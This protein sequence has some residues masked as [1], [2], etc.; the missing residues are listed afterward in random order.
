M[1]TGVTS[2]D[3]H[4]LEHHIICHIVEWTLHQDGCVK[5]NFDISCCDCSDIGVGD[6]LCD[7]NAY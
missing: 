5:L 7:N 6:L 1:C 3:I 4:S 2:V